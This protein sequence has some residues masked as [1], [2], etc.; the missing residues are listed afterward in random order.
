MQRNDSE[1]LLWLFRDAGIDG[2]GET[3]IHEEAG[4][5]ASALGRDDPNDD[6]YLA[7]LRTAI[8][9]AISRAAG[10]TDK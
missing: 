5:N 1:R 7:A 9:R 8:D 2:I 4:I 10:R 3:D 6:D